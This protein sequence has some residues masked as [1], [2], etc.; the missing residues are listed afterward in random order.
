MKFLY[1]FLPVLLFFIAYKLYDIYVATAVIIIASACQVGWTWLRHRRVERMP[2][3]TLALL[4]LLG[5]ATLILQDEMFLKWKPTVVN[6]L[7]GLVFLGS[8]FIG[9]KP[10]IERM[11]GQAMELP[12]TAWVRLNLAW[13]AFFVVMGILN[14]IVAFNFDTDTWVDFKLFGILGLTLIFVLAQGIYLARYLN[15]DTKTEE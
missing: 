6:W 5:G 14:L 4:I 2:L 12:S 1:D 3:I 8:Q 11:L 10:V 15:I 7:F 9:N 13:A